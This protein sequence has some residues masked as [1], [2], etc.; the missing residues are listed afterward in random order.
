MQNEEFALKARRE[1]IEEEIVWGAGEGLL[2]GE[3]PIRATMRG[4]ARRLLC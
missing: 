1:Q 3:L 2:E 4:E